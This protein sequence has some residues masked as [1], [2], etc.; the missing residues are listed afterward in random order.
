MD[1]AAENGIPVFASADG[2]VRYA[3]WH[4][5]GKNEKGQDNPGESAGIHVR[6]EYNGDTKTPGT[7]A[8]SGAMHLNKAAVSTGQRVVQGQLIG[9]VGRTGVHNSGSHLHYQMEK[10]T[11]NG[12]TE[13]VD[14]PADF[15]N[16]SAF[17]PSSSL[18]R[19]PDTNSC[20]AYGDKFRKFI[21]LN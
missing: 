16:Y 3:G 1:T 21:A 9:E 18:Y 13:L 5:D 2:V 12:G 17:D 15:L 14:N 4:H 19:G 6:I 20:R 10:W 11:A 8:Y 7:L